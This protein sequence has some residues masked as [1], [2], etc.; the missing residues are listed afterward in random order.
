[1]SGRRDKWTRKVFSP[2]YAIRTTRIAEFKSFVSAAAAAA[3]ALAS[4]SARLPGIFSLMPGEISSDGFKSFI[5]I[6]A[7]GEASNLIAM[8]TRS[9]PSFTTY[10]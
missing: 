9:S 5:S 2:S 8:E 3:S 6:T 10:S 1:M 7:L 4:S